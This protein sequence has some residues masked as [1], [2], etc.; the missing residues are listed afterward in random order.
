[1]LLT[2]VTLAGTAIPCES[3]Y[4]AVWLTC[5]A[6]SLLSLLIVATRDE[7][8]SHDRTRQPLAEH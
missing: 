5:G 4:V 7:G 8:S 6:A 3:A 2:R 1:V